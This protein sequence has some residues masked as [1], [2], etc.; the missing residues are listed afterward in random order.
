MKVQFESI[1][2]NGHFEKLTVYVTVYGHRV[3]E[4]F[5]Y[6]IENG[7]ELIV[8]GGYKDDKFMFAKLNEAFCFAKGMAFA[9]SRSGYLFQGEWRAAELRERR[10]A[11]QKHKNKSKS[12]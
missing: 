7:Y 9:H 8:A 5:I 10:K 11:Y 12:L 6:P 4:A 3:D 1:I 2:I